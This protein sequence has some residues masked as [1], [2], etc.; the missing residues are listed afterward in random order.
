VNVGWIWTVNLQPFL[1]IVS[2][3]VGYAF[4]ASDWTAIELG[5]TGTDSE[6]GPW[7]DYPVGQLAVNVAFEPGAHEMVS[8]RID[9]DTTKTE[10]KIRWLTELLR[11]Y[12]L[13]SRG[14]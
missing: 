2:H 6:H 14:R 8:I 5:L 13:R 7:F 1:E 10:T 4:A 9:G 3:E 12:E 11:D